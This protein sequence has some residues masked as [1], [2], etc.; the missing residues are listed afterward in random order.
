MRVIVSTQVAYDVI[1]VKALLY[2]YKPAS[3]PTNV[4]S[5]PPP[6][7]YNPLPPNRNKPTRVVVITGSSRRRGRRAFVVADLDRG[8][9]L[10]RRG[11]RALCSS[12]VAHLCC[13][14]F[15]TDA[16]IVGHTRLYNFLCYHS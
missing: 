9:M 3:T 10:F 12:F 14:S 13:H 15:I 4:R 2:L 16:H 5:L 7:N 6:Q 8:C 1:A 11:R